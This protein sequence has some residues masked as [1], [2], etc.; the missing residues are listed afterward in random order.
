[1][2]RPRETEEDIPSLE[3]PVPSREASPNK[4]SFPAGIKI[5]L[6]HASPRSRL[7]SPALSS[8]STDRT[9][10]REPRETSEEPQSKILELD[11]SSQTEDNDDGHAMKCSLP[12]HKFPIR[13]ATYEEYEAHYTKNHTNRCRE[14]GKNFPSEHLLSLHIE[15]VH[16]SFAA[17]KRERGEHTFS[18]FVETCD[19]KCMTASK[20]NRHLVDKHHFPRNYFFS[21]TTRGID[22][23]M[24]MLNEE[25]RWKR[26]QHHEPRGQQEYTKKAPI[27]LGDPVTE[28]RTYPIRG[29]PEATAHVTAPSTTDGDPIELDPVVDDTAQERRPEPVDV[30]MDDLAGAMSSLQFV[31]QSI[32]FGRGR[33]GFSKH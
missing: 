25:P 12:G 18:C 28:P 4:T 9:G 5:P 7:A 3:E 13:F 30:Q 19:R 1:M 29:Q 16:D 2:K 33:K 8:T 32:R 15:E 14:C 17:V 11:P 31:P 23:R 22:G 26:N 6:S 20:R 21:V 24:S 27:A 10:P